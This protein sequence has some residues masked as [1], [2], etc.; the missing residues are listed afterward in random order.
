M[1]KSQHNHKPVRILANDD[2]VRDWLK[3]VQNT[4]ELQQFLLVSAPDALVRPASIPIEPRPSSAERYCL[5]AGSFDPVHDGHLQ[6][7]E[8]A[9]QNYRLRGCWFEVCISNVDKGDLQLKRLLDRLGQDFQGHGLLVSTAPTFAGK[10]ELF[11]GATF[12]VGADTIKRIGQLKYYQNSQAEFERAMG[13]IEASDC[14]FLVFGRTMDGKFVEASSLHLPECVRRLC[15]F[16]SEED[17][18][19][20]VSST[21]IRQRDQH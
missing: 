2:K 14:R 12:A 16:V 7:A 8:F 21:E 20:D 13:Q 9:V 10:A 15:H 5:L 18:K 1:A 19:R 17:F 3:S 4:N 11:P 6:M